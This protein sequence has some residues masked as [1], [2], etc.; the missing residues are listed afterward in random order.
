MLVKRFCEPKNE[1]RSWKTWFFD[2]TKQI[3]GCLIIHFINILISEI[4]PGTL[5]P[6]T[7]YLIS[8][9][10]DTTIGL[11]LIYVFIKLVLYFASKLDIPTLQFGFYGT[12]NAK[13]TYWLHQTVA[14]III[15]LI[16][17]VIII[18]ILQWYRRYQS[19]DLI[20]WLM[21]ISQELEVA[22]TILIIPFFVNVLVFWI[23]DNF[24]TMSS[25]STKKILNFTSSSQTVVKK[26]A[27]I[28]KCITTSA[29]LVNMYDIMFISTK[30]KLKNEEDDNLVEINLETIE[31]QT[32]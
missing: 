1:R 5:N 18:I 23:T 28:K 4:W 7:L 13:V 15:L 11:F 14:Y 20:R 10:L 16:Q 32:V 9:I 27:N 26:L 3:I 31:N 25:H 2:T 17:K 21:P 30:Q 29:K 12:P 8:F 22:I 24:L 6:C 19:R